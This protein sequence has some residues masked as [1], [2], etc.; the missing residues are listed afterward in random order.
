M[1]FVF[2]GS[3]VAAGS[4]QRLVL[5]RSLT[6]VV[7]L[8]RR[9][10]RAMAPLYAAV[11]VLL[12][13]LRDDPLFAITIPSKIQTYLAAGLPLLV[14]LRGDAADLVQAAGAG[15]VC[16]PEEPVAL[17]ACVQHFFEMPATERA[18]MG[19]N[20]RAYYA[21]YL[22]MPLGVDAL[23]AE[24]KCAAGVLTAVGDQAEPMG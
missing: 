10:P 1:Q 2:V 17:A 23:L 24:L 12:V 16:I 9:P 20:G 15:L 3:G 19:E 6:N 18:R 5:E 11:D 22:D 14:A 8:P 7:V 4:L 13:H 21:K